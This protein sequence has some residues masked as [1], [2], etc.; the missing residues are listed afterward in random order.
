M[1]GRPLTRDRRRGAH[2]LDGPTLRRLSKVAVL[3]HRRSPTPSK[4]PESGR[5]VIEDSDNGP[6]R[7]VAHEGERRR[8]QRGRGPLVHR[9]ADS[10]TSSAPIG[11]RIRFYASSPREPAVALQRHARPLQ[12]LADR[13]STQARPTRRR[14]APSRALRTS[15][16]PPPSSST[17]CCSWKARVSRPRPPDWCETSGPWPTTRSRPVTGSPPP[18]RRRGTWPPPWWRWRISLTSSASATA[19]SPTT[20]RPPT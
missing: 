9:G 13:W 5:R 7:S 14:S 10:L 2:L 15:T 19:S 16:T 3:A 4:A 12:A 18:C 11:S 17:A 20:G 8:G 1:L 6:N